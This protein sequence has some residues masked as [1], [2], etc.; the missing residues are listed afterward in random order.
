MDERLGFVR[1]SAGALFTAAIGVL[2]LWPQVAD[3]AVMPPAAP[4]GG[5]L[6]IFDYAV[7][8]VFMA[9]A[10]GALLVVALLN[11]RR[12]PELLAA[13]MA[14]SIVLHL[15]SFS[16]FS[17]ARVRSEYVEPPP[18]SHVNLHRIKVG[19]PVLRESLASQSVRAK[20]P[21]AETADL[22]AQ[23]ET[24]RAAKSQ[25]V[26][27][28]PER[29]RADI[30]ESVRMAEGMELKTPGLNPPK[31]SVD[32]TLKT[33]ASRPVEIAEVKIAAQTAQGEAQAGAPGVKPKE[34][35]KQFDVAPVVK[36][37]APP[38]PPATAQ[39]AGL[40]DS[41]QAPIRAEIG[42]AAA[43]SQP[44][45][46]KD[47][48]QPADA[49]L[50][51]DRLD[52]PTGTIKRT[53]EPEKGKQDASL[54]TAA[55]V[56]LD[57]RS[58]GAPATAGQRMPEAARSAVQPRMAADSIAVELPDGIER[59]KSDVA[60]IAPAAGNDAPDL[61]PLRLNG[62]PQTLI[63][64]SREAPAAAPEAATGQPE[65]AASKEKLKV[66]A[67]DAKP[68]AAVSDATR[69]AE[70]IR[71]G[72]KN[73]VPVEPGS[74][75][76]HVVLEAIAEVPAESAG[77][78]ALPGPF[79]VMKPI[80]NDQRATGIVADKPVPS[81]L[82]VV[83]QGGGFV[84]PRNVTAPVAARRADIS[85]DGRTAS[86][87]LIAES[88]ANPKSRDSASGKINE[89]LAD[90]RDGAERRMG[91]AGVNVPAQSA[92]DVARGS[93]PEVKQA[94]A[95]PAA[96]APVRARTG[97]VLADAGGAP[98]PVAGVSSEL[99]AGDKSFVGRNADAGAPVRAG[100]AGSAIE[101]VA[102]AS[103][104][105]L[106]DIKGV[107]VP[108]A[109]ARA[110]AGPQTGGGAVAMVA[111]PA[112][113][114]LEKSGGGAGAELP[115][116]RAGGVPGPALLDAA[117]DA[118]GT[119]VAQANLGGSGRP[120]AGAAPRESLA[121][122]RT[123]AAVASGRGPELGAQPVLGAQPA[124]GDSSPAGPV[125]PLT[126]AR[127][128][129]SG[130]PKLDRLRDSG[131]GASTAASA[132]E[133][134]AP[135]RLDLHPGEEASRARLASDISVAFSTQAVHRSF[136]PVGSAPDPDS[137]P[138]KAIYKMRKP[139]K[140]RQFIAELGGTPQTEEAVEQA[141]V[142][143]S[144]TQ[145]DDGRW[146]VD[147]FKTLDE[148]GGAGDLAGED[149]AVSGMALLAFLGAGYTHLDGLH[150]ETV[151][152]GLDWL[153]NCED[154]DGDFRGTGQMYGQAI[155]TVVLCEAY[156]L[157]ADDRLLASSRRAVQFI[158]DAQT[159]GS[160][161][162][163]GPTDD[164]DTS[165]TGWQILALKSAGIA[166]IAV[167]EQTFKWTEQ[168]LDN[169]RQ[170]N[171]GGLY[172]FKPR[173]PVTHVMTAEGLFCQLFMNE[174]TRTRGQDESIAYIME[175][176][177]GWDEKNNSIHMYYWYYSTLSLYL[178]GAKEFDA[179]N[180]ALTK[181][182]LNGRRTSGPAAGSWDP[183]CQLGP[184]GGR[185]Y[186]TSI[187]ALCL[188]VYYRFLPLYKQGNHGPDAIKQ[189]MD[190]GHSSL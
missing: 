175:E 165:V 50:T 190:D 88:Q 115:A 180:A 64:A 125:Q 95:R 59:K 65:W 96:L 76:S 87:S 16:I 84:D 173:H 71:T 102:A 55:D 124:L 11:R 148:C 179:W 118:S 15:L 41:V 139:E 3:C 187:G 188:Q 58:G 170:G 159:P 1:R 56:T 93:S 63:A 70:P 35:E 184:R 53:S 23:M 105:T 94:D 122:V 92:A 61:A 25:P 164:S 189:K 145:S 123:S 133:E 144:R 44:V 90:A 86:G 20:L 177:P 151:R 160:G 140:R 26:P 36:A 28:A 112:E 141:L 109:A 101:Q 130:M 103:A 69:P 80:G 9:M 2:G 99:P 49:K 8:N 97:N 62:V 147:G 81:E 66:E 13:C 17:L 89:H 104:A 39:R 6:L 137:V 82:G 176:L 52:V 32:E 33:E 45:E 182:L 27:E 134:R 46:V 4:G 127:V 166:G 31:Q 29:M 155:A 74:K 106:T 163:Y 57:K 167:P 85:E 142:W 100:S 183:V 22:H 108:V 40:K 143:L 156:S 98:R 111:A 79:P 77:L 135:G 91:P 136:L 30:Q 161:W 14:L 131:A 72:I 119:L 7:L 138:E 51:P 132:V 128:E 83:K 172:A 47:A 18:A 5:A 120:A 126:V 116:V 34:I 78:P 150:K 152:K 60:R 73:A 121:D 75:E 186:S 178:S 174:Q 42:L 169:V 168:W 129:R 38:A 19:S 21:Q 12:R 113:L 68:S 24:V 181:A 10:I 54:Q 162:R 107:A 171:E 157:S 153:L 185:I 117:G 48:I 158:I 43:S 37:S 110:Q 114:A 149:V 67:S 146:D 154:D